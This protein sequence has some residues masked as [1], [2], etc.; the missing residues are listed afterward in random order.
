MVGGI[1][2]GLTRLQDRT[3]VHVE[4][5]PHY[6][7]HGSIDE[8]PRPDACCVYTDE[9]RISDGMK[10]EIALG[11][12]LWWRDSKCYWTPHMNLGREDSMCGVD[13]DIALRKIGY[14]H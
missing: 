6:P 3:R 11:D 5:C 1:V 13:Y 2:I 4:E 12:S 9:T 8:C 14:S 10:V 7:R